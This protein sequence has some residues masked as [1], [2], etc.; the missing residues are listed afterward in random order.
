MPR[1]R[2]QRWEQRGRNADAFDSPE[3]PK[4]R[5]HGITENGQL[6][7]ERRSS[8][9]TGD[10]GAETILMTRSKECRSSTFGLVSSVKMRDGTAEVIMNNFKPDWSRQRR[11]KNRLDDNA[12][13]HSK[14][15]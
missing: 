9:T 5:K 3:I 12:D 15:V 1:D 8:R 13:G 4:R 6:P 10:G 11:P 14:T 7:P 2:K